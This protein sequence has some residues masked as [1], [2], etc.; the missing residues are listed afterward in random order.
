MINTHQYFVTANFLNHK[1]HIIIFFFCSDRCVAL[2]MTSD[3]LIQSDI[4]QSA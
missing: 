1:T 2:I 3:A 4:K